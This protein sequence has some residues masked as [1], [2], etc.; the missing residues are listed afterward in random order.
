ML[1][2][3]T[4]SLIFVAAAT[5][6]VFV[7]TRSEPTYRP[8][9]AV[10]GLTAGLDRSVPG[11]YPRITFTDVTE[12]AGIIKHL[13]AGMGMVCADYDLDADTDIFIANDIS[14]GNF[15]FKNDGT[16][17][18]DEIGLMAGLAYDLHGD[19]QGSMGV[20]VG[21]YDNDGIFDFYVTSYQ[22]Q[23]ATLYKGLGDDTFEDVTR[24]T[25]AGTTRAGRTGRTG[26][27][28]NQ[29]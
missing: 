23:T 2:T 16:G 11:D 28:S 6:I 25:G 12:Q 29:P 9:E 15:L 1:T 10:E 24:T 26:R 5:A 21:D 22:R 18:F 20:D 3:A 14:A 27:T 17:K 8:G 4:F 19:E 7:T 13:G